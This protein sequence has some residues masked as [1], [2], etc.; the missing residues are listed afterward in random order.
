MA[1]VLSDESGSDT[2]DVQSSDGVDF[3]KT[4]SWCEYKGAKEDSEGNP[5]VKIEFRF[6]PTVYCDMN[7][8]PLYPQVQQDTIVGGRDNGK[9]SINLAVPRTYIMDYIPKEFTII[10]DTITHNDEDFTI[11][12][13][14]YDGYATLQAELHASFTRK[15][16]VVSFITILDKDMLTDEYL[17]GQKAL[18]TNGKTIDSSVDSFG[19]SHLTYDFWDLKL[20]SPSLVYGK[21]TDE[22]IT[23]AAKGGK[24]YVEKDDDSEKYD[25]TPATEDVLDYRKW[26]WIIMIVGS[27]MMLV[28]KI[29]RRYWVEN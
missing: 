1:Y 6:D 12:V 14:S 28:N 27:G 13:T 7:G 3:S 4:A 17:K 2:K 15:E 19:S 21:N 20:E 18:N 10:E 26:L 5:Y 11:T 22:D 9:L 29:Y 23:D 24:D 25:E 8:Y 16:Y